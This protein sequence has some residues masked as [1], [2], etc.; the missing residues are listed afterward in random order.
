MKYSAGEDGDAAAATAAAAG[1]LPDTCSIGVDERG[2]RSCVVRVGELGRAARCAT[3]G[4]N[5]CGKKHAE[6]E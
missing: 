4:A 5:P 2:P 6:N 1:D 3:E